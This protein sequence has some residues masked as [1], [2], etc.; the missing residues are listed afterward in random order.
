M[1]GKTIIASG[2]VVLGVVL[3]GAGL[4]YTVK[5]AALYTTDGAPGT[6]HFFIPALS[7]LGGT[8]LAAMGAIVLAHRWRGIR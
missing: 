4:G 8:T 3:L 7:L 6:S 2:L 1:S 5:Q